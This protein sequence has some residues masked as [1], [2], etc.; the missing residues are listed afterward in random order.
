MTWREGAETLMRHLPDVVICEDA[1]PDGD[2]KLAL[3]QTSPLKNAPRLIVV[4]SHANESL[5]VEVLNWG[6]YDLLSRPLVEDEV[7][8]VV[9]LA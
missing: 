8:R 2:W 5:W 3:G 9:G 6:G 1:L 4:S 7:V